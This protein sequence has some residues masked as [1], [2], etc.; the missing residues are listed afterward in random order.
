MSSTNLRIRFIRKNGAPKNDDT[1]VI[2]RLGMNQFILNYTYGDTTAKN[3]HKLVL[4]DKAVFRWMRNTVN[5]VE[6]DNDPFDSVQVDFPFMPSVLFDVSKLSD[7]YHYILD[8]VEFHLDNWPE[9]ELQAEEEEEEEEE[10]AEAEEED[11]YA[12]MPS[13][14][15]SSPIEHTHNFNNNYIYN[16]TQVRGR[17]H[18]FLD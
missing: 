11:E 2:S 1:V 4:T 3:T 14:I 6:K 8:A 10:D 12:D 15:P 13:L 16:T 17:H 18:L 7:A 9:E 5:L